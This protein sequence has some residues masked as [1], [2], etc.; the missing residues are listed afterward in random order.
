MHPQKTNFCSHFYSNTRIK[1]KLK[2]LFPIQYR[3]QTFEIVY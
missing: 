2:G 3:K 1:E